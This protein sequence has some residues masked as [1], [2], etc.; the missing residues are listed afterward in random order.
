MITE[1]KVREL[2]NSL[3]YAYG[4]LREGVITEWLEQNQPSPIVVGLSD[5]QVDELSY[6]LEY[7]EWGY[8]GVIHNYLKTQTLIQPQQFQPSW[9]GVPTEAVLARV[10]VKYLHEDGYSSVHADKVLAQFERPKSTPK[11]EVGQVWCYGA[12]ECTVVDV[13]STEVAIKNNYSSKLSVMGLSEF[14][15]KFYCYVPTI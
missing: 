8:K 3:D 7:V 14:L 1:D 4:K 5:E 9:D 6:L 10:V 12:I 15:H 13:T 2:S 11:V